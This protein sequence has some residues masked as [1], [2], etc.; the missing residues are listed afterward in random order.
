[1]AEA[2]DDAVNRRIYWHLDHALQRFV[3]RRCDGLAGV[4]LLPSLGRQPPDLCS[5]AYSAGFDVSLFFERLESIPY[6][7]WGVSHVL[8][9]FGGCDYRTRSDG[10]RP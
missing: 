7:V 10:Y 4:Q 3:Q 2:I 6:P 9:E 8:G 5:S 1:M